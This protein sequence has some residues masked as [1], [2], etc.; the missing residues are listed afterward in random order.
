MID[1]PLSGQ[2][3]YKRSLPASAVVWNLLKPLLCLAS[4]ARQR[5][6]NTQVEDVL[7]QHSGVREAA[8]VISTIY[9]QE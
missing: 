9:I 5:V 8:G 1:N 6:K 3:A 7:Y 4:F 2:Q